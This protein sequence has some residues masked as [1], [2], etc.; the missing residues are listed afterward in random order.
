VAVGAAVALALHNIPEGVSTALP[1]YHA[2]GSRAKACWFSSLTGLAE[3]FGALIVYSLTYRFLSG[4]ALSVLSGA[5]A[6]ILV[7]VALDGMLPAARV[8]GEN[9]RAILGVL[10]G[11]LAAAALSL[12]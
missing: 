3:P 4:E 11:M 9:H 6:G 2:T 1:M 5:S 7:F 10:L 12:L 8:F